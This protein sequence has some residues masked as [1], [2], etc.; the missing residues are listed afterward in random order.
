MSDASW[1]R[2]DGADIVLQVLVQ[3][4]ASREAFGAVVGD[5]I[6]VSLTAP[7]VEGAANE[8]LRAFLAKQF[9]VPRNRVE[10]E[11]GESGRRKRVRIRSVAMLP[12]T[13][14]QLNASRGKDQR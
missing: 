4:R 7:P 12:P 6:K 1:W 14:A 2:R 5:R 13:L 10:L 11:S 9:R 3:P 8:A